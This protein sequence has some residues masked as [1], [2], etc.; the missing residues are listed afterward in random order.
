MDGDCS[1]SCHTVVGVWDLGPFLPACS[2]EAYSIVGRSAGSVTMLS[3][4]TRGFSNLCVASSSLRV[5]VA[6]VPVPYL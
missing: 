3:V 6:A 5:S 2:I 1:R 4:C